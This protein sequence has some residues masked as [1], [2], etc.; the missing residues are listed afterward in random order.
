MLHASFTWTDPDSSFVLGPATPPLSISEELQPLVDQWIGTF[1]Q[2][3]DLPAA[4][5]RALNLVLRTRPE[6]EDGFM[7]V[8]TAMYTGL[9]AEMVGRSLEESVERVDWYIQ[10]ETALLYANFEKKQ[11]SGRP[12][13]SQVI[14]DIEQ[15]REQ[16]GLFIAHEMRRYPSLIQGVQNESHLYQNRIVDPEYLPQVIHSVGEQ[17]ANRHQQTLIEMFREGEQ[18]LAAFSKKVTGRK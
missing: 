11:A 18:E 15:C 2:S 13:R 4:H 8:L 3:D 10:H 14:Q 5:T 16:I 1:Q 12:R 6:R 7:K 9:A 17:L